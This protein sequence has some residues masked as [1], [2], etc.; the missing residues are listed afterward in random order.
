MFEEIE[1]QLYERTCETQ[2]K[3][4]QEE[5][6]E[7]A[8]RFPHLRFAHTHAHTQICGHQECLSSLGLGL[9]D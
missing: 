2:L 4:L 1:E 8:S 3:G 5:C 7:W 6:Q 9:R